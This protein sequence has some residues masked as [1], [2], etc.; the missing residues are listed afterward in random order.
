MIVYAFDIGGT[1][2]KHAL[3]DTE[4][5]PKPIIVRKKTRYHGTNNFEG[6]KKIVL[7]MIAETLSEGMNFSCI[8]ISTTGGV[9]LDG[10]VMSSGFFTGYGGKSWKEVLSH[11]YPELGN[12][13]TMNDGRASAWAE[14]LACS[15][16]S[17]IFVHFVLGT[18][19]GGSTIIDGKLV[20]GDY[21]A[22]GYLGHIKVSCSSTDVCSCGRTGC[23]E[24]FA[25]GP[26]ILREYRNAKG[27]ENDADELDVNDVVRAYANGNR[28]AIDCIDD[29]ADK[30]GMA[31]SDIM[32]ILNPGVV[33][34]G[35]GVSLALGEIENE[36]FLKKVKKSARERAHK[37]VEDTNIRMA[38]LGNDAG[39]IGAAMASVR[40]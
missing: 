1:S 31:I 5:W 23:V 8:A 38:T 2:V 27:I 9:D 33:T 21:G 26:S 25:S 39:M 24:T 32:N 15:L 30:L 22:A 35:G 11:S 6:L 3:L 34:I 12:V 4:K 37:K 36:L 7:E 29:A 10:R 28:A 14:Y 16:Q 17:N 13:Y 19:I 40:A 18:G 20:T